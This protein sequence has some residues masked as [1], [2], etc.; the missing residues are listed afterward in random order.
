MARRR[1]S[2]RAKTPRPAG[3][4]QSPINPP[5]ERKRKRTR[6]KAIDAIPM[7]LARERGRGETFLGPAGGPVGVI[8]FR[9]PEGGGTALAF[10]RALH[11]IAP[12][13]IGELLKQA[14]EVLKQLVAAEIGEVDCDTASEE[15][16]RDEAL[17]EEKDRD[18]ALQHVPGWL[19]LTPNEVG[20]A[21]EKILNVI[22]QY[23]VRTWWELLWCLA[24][25]ATRPKKRGRKGIWLGSDGLLLVH[26]LNE[27]LRATGLSSGKGLDRAIEVVKA[28]R[29]ERYSEY[30]NGTLR[31]AYYDA[32]PL[33]VALC[34]EL[35]G[36]S[37]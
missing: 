31:A 14:N 16:D 12:D 5:I 33:Y 3:R 29:P 36:N 18:E 22:H 30:S 8:D 24:V 37:A 32:L 10:W 19:N 7:L 2:A 23:P 9:A 25:D 27:Q 20:H 21:A 26:R 1:K 17:Q 4:P 6:P 28:A 13:Q 11:S 34:P 15:K 35:L